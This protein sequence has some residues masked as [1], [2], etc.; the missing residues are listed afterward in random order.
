MAGPLSKVVRH[1]WN[2][3]LHILINDIEIVIKS[4]TKYGWDEPIADGSEPKLW[5]H[6]IFYPDR[7]PYK[8]E[9][10]DTIRS[11]TKTK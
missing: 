2:M 5:F 6:E 1:A 3:R 4:N 9:E 10:V 7:T 8:Q 11:L